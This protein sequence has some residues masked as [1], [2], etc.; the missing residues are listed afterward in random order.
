MN[1][2]FTS[3]SPGLIS[4]ISNFPSESV[5]PPVAML[6]SESIIEMDVYSIGWPEIESIT[7]P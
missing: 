2:I 1:S 5:T 7:M 4:S 6:L 3:Y